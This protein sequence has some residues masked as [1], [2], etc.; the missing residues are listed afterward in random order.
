MGSESVPFVLA[1]WAR[2]CST[3]SVVR[4]GEREEERRGRRGRGRGGRGREEAGG[5]HGGAADIQ[6]CKHVY[7]HTHH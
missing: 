4:E 7:T 6:I 1:S 2:D 5:E 3:S